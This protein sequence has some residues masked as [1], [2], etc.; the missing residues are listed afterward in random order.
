MTLIS[1]LVGGLLGGTLI[2]ALIYIKMKAEV[3]T[4]E[5]KLSMLNQ[6]LLQQ[7]DLGQRMSQSMTQQFEVMAQKIFEEKSTKFADQNHKNI[8]SVLEPLKE[9]LKD[10]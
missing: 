7:E 10:F 4:A 6:N 9:R 2:G 5:V 1:F 3:Q 8:S